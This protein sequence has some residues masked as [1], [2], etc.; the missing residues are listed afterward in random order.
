MICASRRSR[1]AQYPAR[2]LGA[3]RMIV[4]ESDVVVMTGDHPCVSEDSDRDRS[5]SV[6]G[7]CCTFRGRFERQ[8]QHTKGGGQC[9]PGRVTGG[10][11]VG[12]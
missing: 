10:S 8:I 5:L 3:M 1:S 11:E 6:M 4:S 12:A 2:I 7:R 9:R